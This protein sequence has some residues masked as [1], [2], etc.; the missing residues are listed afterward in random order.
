[1]A[2]LV[3]V[4]PL[5]AIAIGKATV[6]DVANK[7]VAIFNVNGNFFAIDDEC[8]HAGASLAEGEINGDQVTCPFHAANFCLR[9]G[10]AL[11]PPARK[12]VKAYRVVIQDGDIH[13]EF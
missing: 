4:T 12:G 2:T 1:M 8:P 3:K 13:L 6:F 5:S 11:C 10:A 7:R 9:T